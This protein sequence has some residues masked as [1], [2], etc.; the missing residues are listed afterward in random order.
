MMGKNCLQALEQSQANP[1]NKVH[2]LRKKVY[3]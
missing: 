2:V 1:E 3:N